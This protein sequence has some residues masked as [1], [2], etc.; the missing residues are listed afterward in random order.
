MRPSSADTSEPACE[1][2]KM[3]STNSSVSAPVTSRNHSH[4]VKADSA[5]RRR[6]PGGSFI[7]P[8]TI[9]VWLSTWRSDLPIF[10]F[11]ISSQRS[12]PSRVRSP[13][14]A[15]TEVPPCWLAMRAI[16]SVRMTVL[17]T[18][19]P[20]NRPALPPRTSGVKRSMTLMP[21]RDLG[22]L[23]RW[24]VK[25]GGVG[26]R[27]PAARAGAGP[28][29]VDRLAERVEDAAERLLADGHGRGPAGVDGLHAADEAVGRAQRD[30]ADA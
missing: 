7:W 30:A 15:Y 18:P 8:K 5:T 6:A 13:T 24:G 3:L 1:K 10:V 22:G 23:G 17:P 12:L 21:G 2:R 28:G 11:C 25:G 19:A 16:S 29:V 26:V 27:G 9:A 4:I 14:P 20:P